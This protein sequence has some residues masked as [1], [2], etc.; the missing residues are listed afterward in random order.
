MEIRITAP[1]SVLAELMRISSESGKLIEVHHS[2]N[3]D[4]DE[5]GHSFARTVF[6][7]FKYEVIVYDA[8]TNG[9]TGV[10]PNSLYEAMLYFGV[11]E[12]DA[13]Q[14]VYEND[15]SFSIRL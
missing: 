3:F 2:N 6:K 14:L 11:N 10:G 15:S 7:F 4:S 13:I 12:K 1:K 8:F 9:H 5:H